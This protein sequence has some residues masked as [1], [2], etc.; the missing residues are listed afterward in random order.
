M[1]QQ[2][3]TPHVRATPRRSLRLQKPKT[4]QAEAGPL[5]QHTPQEHKP[6]NQPSSSHK[7]TSKLPDLS[8]ELHRLIISY[9]ITSER[10]FL[11]GR[12]QEERHKTRGSPRD[13]ISAH[14]PE[15]TVQRNDS[16]NRP[17]QPAISR[18]CRAF[19]EEALRLW[20]SENHFW[21]IHNEFEPEV[22][23]PNP[24]R[25]FDAWISQTS[26]DMFNHMQH[27][28]LCGYSTWPNRM[29]ISIDLKNRRID[30]IR[31]YS[32]YG[33]ELP[34]WQQM[35]ID[36]TKQALASQAGADGLAALK[37]VLAV[38]DDIFQIPREYITAPPGMMRRQ[39]A[40]GWEYDW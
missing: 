14:K 1:S 17:I 20:Y 28:T 36:S 29:M 3:S 2:I 11:I 24:R 38:R 34:I 10:P 35:F 18:V 9:L 12:C 15:F 25:G 13:I 23:V 8:A 31:H 21:L 27:V 40:S 7:S 33:D 5:G 19:R 6:S 37:A 32:T 16:R 26:R 22:N 39:P 4:I 30:H